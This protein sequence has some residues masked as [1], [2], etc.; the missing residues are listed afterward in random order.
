MKFHSRTLAQTCYTPCLHTSSTFKRGLFVTLYYVT[1][2]Y[3]LETH[4]IAI[5]APPACRS[6]TTSPPALGVLLAC[7]Q[8]SVGARRSYALCGDGPSSEVLTAREVLL[9]RSS[10]RRSSPIFLFRLCICIRES[11]QVQSSRRGWQAACEQGIEKQGAIRPERLRGAGGPHT[12]RGPHE[13]AS[14]TGSSPRAEVVVGQASPESARRESLRHAHGAAWHEPKSSLAQISVLV[15]VCCRNE[16][17]ITSGC[18]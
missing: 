9:E 10:L 16:V 14:M 4:S 8:R 11:H 18:R 3:Q 7:S 6:T 12:K 17:R 5:C 1:Y 2:E 15:A 13:E